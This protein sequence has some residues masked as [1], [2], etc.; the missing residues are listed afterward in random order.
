MRGTPTIGPA[1]HGR[2]LELSV[3]CRTHKNASRGRAHSVLIAEDWS[4]TTPHDLEAERVAAAFGGY[5]S[6]LELVDRIIPAVAQ[7]MGI[8]ARTSPLP[9]RRAEDRRTWTIPIVRGCKCSRGSFKSPQAAGAHLRSS[10]HLAR[11]FKV[12]SRRLD[13]VLQAVLAAS[14]V[15]TLQSH[16]DAVV[17]AEAF[18]HEEAGVRDL[19]L[20][21]VHPGLI[22][23]LADHAQAVEEPLPVAYYLGLTYGNPD[24][25]WLRATT[26]ARPDPTVASWLAWVPHDSAL[27]TDDTG[28]WLRLGLSQRE[29]EL[30]TA[31]NISPGA[32]RELAYRSVRTPHAAARD[33]VGWAAADCR[34][35]VEQMLL[36]DRHGLAS[37]HPSSAAVDHLVDYARSCRGA[38]DRTELG[39]MLS[40]AGN[41]QAVQRFLDEGVRTAEMLAA[42]QVTIDGA[43]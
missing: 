6:C 30:A 18:L 33:L 35:T 14:P 22:P 39:V 2:V 41:R 38:P 26:R 4:V 1:G 5:T 12:S 43:A 24:L 36:L 42:R 9:M 23:R 3:E 34:P 15:T 8:L 32:A 11:Q 40:I 37:S 25:S 29:V 7:S 27:V 17:T 13:E 10:E 21:G 19:W 16:A 28:E 31:T 20:A